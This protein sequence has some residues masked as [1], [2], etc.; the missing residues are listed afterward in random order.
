MKKIV[1]VIDTLSIGGAELLLKNS[2]ELL[3]EYEHIVAYLNEPD[4]LRKEV[5]NSHVHFINLQH[6]GWTKIF[7]TA[8]QLRKVIKFAK[9]SIVH[10]H[11]F[12]STICARLATPKS[13]RLVSSIHSIYSKD[14]FHKNIKSLLAEKLTL[15]ERHTI[16]AVS[17]FVL[18][19]YLCYVPFAGKRFVLYNFLPNGSF[20]E[21]QV[22]LTKNSLRCVA[23]GN[24]KEAKN[25][26]YL[27]DIWEEIKQQDISL[28]IYGTGALE[29]ELKVMIRKKGLN[30][31]LCG[32]ASNVQNLLRQYD[33]FVQASTHEGFGLSVIEAIASRVPVL[34]SD[35]PV[36]S[37]ITSN[38]AHFF[39]L[40]DSKKATEIL[41]DLYVNQESRNRHVADAYAF[42][43]QTFSADAF[44]QKLLTIYQINSK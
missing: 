19:D 44:K 22:K 28:D 13:V 17:K 40:T 18:N 4:E 9:P 14:A 24:L 2:I 12:V 7:N 3:P 23:V 5:W 25:Y 10:S 32:R 31:K 26:Q 11:L 37:E 21:E 43:K 42:C 35:I 15:R 41:L 34:I 27:F 38:H 33:L 39:P 30:I 36:F 29:A 1:H 6:T 20:V 8:R 16:I